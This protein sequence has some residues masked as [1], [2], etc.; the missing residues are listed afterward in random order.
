LCWSFFN[1]NN[2][3]KFTFNALQFMCCMF[4]YL[5]IIFFRNTRTKLKKGLISY[6]KTSE[7]TCL[8]KHVDAYHCIIKILLI[9]QLFHKRKF[10]KTTYYIYIWLIHF[11]FFC[12][13]KAFQEIWCGVE[14]VFGRSCIFGSEK[15]FAFI[16]HE[17]CLSKLFHLAFVPSSSI[18][19][20]I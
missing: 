11:L 18:S 10:G 2:N 3:A 16:V 9:N 1:V 12:F 14:K 20:T 8:R 7:I 19:F 5:N 4:F 13:K 15:R 17:W 6:Y